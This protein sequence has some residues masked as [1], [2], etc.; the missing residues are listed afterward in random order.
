MRERERKGRECLIHEDGNEDSLVPVCV[1]VC[2]SVCA[3][4][5]KRQ[6]WMKAHVARNSGTP[7]DL[8]LT[9][10]RQQIHS[11]AMQ[12]VTSKTRCLTNAQKLAPPHGCAANDTFDGTVPRV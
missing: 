3:V 7:P 5:I 8:L 10:G 9:H 11:H 12:F 1:D 6:P 4:K 2:V